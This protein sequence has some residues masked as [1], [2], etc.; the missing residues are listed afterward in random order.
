MVLVAAIL[1]GLII[2][3]VPLAL[4]LITGETR[5][6]LLLVAGAVL[7]LPLARMVKANTPRPYTPDALPDE[8]MR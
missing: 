2:V 8:L 6:F 1:L 7:A 5:A 4:V 3:A